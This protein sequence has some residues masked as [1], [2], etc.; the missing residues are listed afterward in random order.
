MRVQF[1]PRASKHRHTFHTP[2]RGK[3]RRKETNMTFTIPLLLG[4]LLA[5]APA[6]PHPHPHPTAPVDDPCW[7]R[8][9]LT[10]RPSPLD[11][12]VARLG[13]A[14]LKVCYGRPSARSRVIMGGLV[15]F[16]EPWRLGANEATTLHTQ[17]AVRF[18]DVTLKP[19]VYSLYAI[20]GPK[21][22][23]IVVNDSATRWGIPIN[24]AVRARDVGTVT[25]TSERTDAP[26]ETLSMRLEPSGEGDLALVTEWERTRLRVTV[27]RAQ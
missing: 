4:T 1:S 24:A 3:G 14:Q 19:G 16:G 17:V 15:P 27:R 2:Q 26:V 21:T 9:A 7:T 11:S 22:W 12:T 6:G 23:Q 25:V 20:P 10:S 8:T 18:G 13:N 5:G